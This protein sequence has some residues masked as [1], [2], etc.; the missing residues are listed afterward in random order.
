[1]TLLKQQ[2][3]MSRTNFAQKKRLFDANMSTLKQLLSD[4]YYD[5]LLA[6]NISTSRR[7]H[8][9]HLRR[10]KDKFQKLTDQHKAPYC[11][12]YDSIKAFDISAPTF[13]GVIKQ[14][15]P[16]IRQDVNVVKNTVINLSDEPLEDEETSLL[17][18]GLKFCPASDNDSVAKTSSKLEPVLKQLGHGVES[19]AAH[20]V[21]STLVNSKQ[22]PSNLNT[23]QTMAFK[24]LKKK[25]KD[26]KIVPADKGNATVVMANSQYQQKMEEHLN[27]GT[28]SLLKKNPTESLSRKLDAVLK[29]LLKEGKINKS[30]YDNSRVLH[31]RAPQIY[32]VPKIHKPANPIRPIVSFYVTPLSALHGQLSEVLK[33]LTLS[34]IRL[35]NSEDFLNKFRTHTDPEY[36]YY[37]SLDVKSLYTTCDLRKAVKT[38]MERIYQ[39][40]SILPS[41]ISPEAIKSLLNFSLDNAYCEF[42]NKFYKQITGGPMGSPLT[43]TLAEI[44]VTDIEQQ[45]LS[46]S[47]HLS[48]TTQNE[49]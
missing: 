3:K 37:C 44:R 10:H 5:K 38:A 13:T 15:K 11:N 39:D 21:T 23:K 7:T 1:M 28:Y 32:G 41:T 29:K 35:K 27:S 4:S 40:P 20:E 6:F 30:F 49:I 47:I 24:S 12:P 36:S 43:V 8:T 31:P 33:P 26:L 14:S 2:L 16:V 19:A 42:D 17:S 18:R 25:S 34:D 9:E 48:S 46:S 45:A 22:K